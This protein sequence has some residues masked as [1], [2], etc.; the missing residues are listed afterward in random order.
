MDNNEVRKI[1]CLK[2]KERVRERLPVFLRGDNYAN[3]AILMLIDMYTAELMRGRCERVK[4]DIIENKVQI[5]SRKNGFDLFKT[6][7]GVALNLGRWVLEEFGD[8]Y[9]F[10]RRNIS[11]GEV[12]YCIIQ[13]ISKSFKLISYVNN[14][15]QILNYKD[16]D[17]CGCGTMTIPTV[18][19]ST[20][21]LEFELDEELLQNKP[22]ADVVLNEFRKVVKTLGASQ[23]TSN[24]DLSIT[25]MTKKEE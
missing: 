7:E 1:R 23:V 2:G 22:D 24:I 8:P 6:K 25:T 5:S 16:G 17:Y 10:G 12:V 15:K 19:D 18:G 9:N 4:L 14:T 13:Y 21:V 11:E 20:L 3:S